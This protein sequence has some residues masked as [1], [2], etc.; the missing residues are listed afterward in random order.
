MEKRAEYIHKHG[1]TSTADQEIQKELALRRGHS[2][3]DSSSSIKNA[4]DTKQ[5]V[6]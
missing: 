6:E 2:L 4:Q 5:S 3:I 1:D